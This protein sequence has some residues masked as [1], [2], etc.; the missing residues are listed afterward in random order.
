MRVRTK[1]R[2]S[3]L[4]QEPS[5]ELMAP[6]NNSPGCKYIHLQWSDL[7][8]NVGVCQLAVGKL[9]MQPIDVLRAFRCDLDVAKCRG[10]T[11]TAGLAIQK[12]AWLRETV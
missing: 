2:T 6:N 4:P 11:G 5:R 1:K 3:Q 12:R 9:L 7:I 8:F 10:V